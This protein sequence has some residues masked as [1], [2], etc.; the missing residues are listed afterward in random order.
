MKNHID[1]KRIAYRIKGL[2]ATPSKEWQAV[3]LENYS[4]KDMFYHYAIPLIFAGSLLIFLGRFFDSG[5]LIAL[6]SF[7]VCSLSSI[8]AIFAGGKLLSEITVGDKDNNETDSFKIIIYS[9][10]IFFIIHSVAEFIG[11]QTI[12]GNI[13]ILSQLFTIRVI[14][15]GIVPVLKT[16]EKQVSYTIISSVLIYIIPVI[17]EK[18]LSILF[19]IP[20]AEF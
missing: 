11:T 14:W 5:F 2:T 3:S 15:T 20:A 4:I 9:Y 16:A 12:L 17:L 19:M 1:I 7:L 8:G 13:L 18:M 10:S 6:K